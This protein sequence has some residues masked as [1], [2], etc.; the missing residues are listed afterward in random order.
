MLYFYCI[1]S[2]FNCTVEWIFKKRPHQVSILLWWIQMGCASFLVR[3]KSAR[4][5]IKDWVFW[6]QWIRKVLV[7]REFWD[8]QMKIWSCRTE[9]K[10]VALVFSVMLKFACILV[11]IEFLDTHEKSLLFVMNSNGFCQFFFF[12]SVKWRS[13]CLLALKMEIL[14]ARV[15]GVSLWL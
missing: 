1:F 2:H 5:L 14:D 3:W 4:F 9:V 12:F 13:A 10:W 6:D 15:K 11:E 7:S 8:T